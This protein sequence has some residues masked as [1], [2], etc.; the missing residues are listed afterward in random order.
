MNDEQYI[1]PTNVQAVEHD[2]QQ[3]ST[4]ISRQ[5]DYLKSHITKLVQQTGGQWSDEWKIKQDTIN[6]AQAQMN[7]QFSHGTGILTN[8]REAI[9]RTDIKNAAEFQR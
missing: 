8:M 9:Q 1:E 7:A 5:I 4:K 3:I 2:M 6:N